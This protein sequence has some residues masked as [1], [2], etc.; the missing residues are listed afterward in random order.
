[1]VQE[2]SFWIAFYFLANRLK[3]LQNRMDDSY[4]SLY[5]LSNLASDNTISEK[6]QGE[7]QLVEPSLARHSPSKDPTN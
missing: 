2:E 1:M 6:K 7:C 3:P 5:T 4:P